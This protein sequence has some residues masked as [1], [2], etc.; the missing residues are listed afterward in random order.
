MAQ[1]V[2]RLIL[3]TALAVGIAANISLLEILPAQTFPSGLNFPS[4]IIID[5][6]DVAYSAKSWYTTQDPKTYQSDV[7]YFYGRT[8]SPAT[9]T[10]T[11]LPVGEYTIYATWPLY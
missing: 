1:T 8:P 2:V 9:W 4:P 3:L 7:G 10:F 6:G 11:N 5:N